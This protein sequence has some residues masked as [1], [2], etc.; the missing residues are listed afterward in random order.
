[1]ASAIHKIEQTRS[2]F[3][4]ESKMSA[5]KSFDYRVFVFICW[6]WETDQLGE[7]ARMSAESLDV[8]AV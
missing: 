6:A 5:R 1:M 8:V 7:E 2:W 3:G 4:S